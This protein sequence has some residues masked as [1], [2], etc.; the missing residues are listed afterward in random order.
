MNNNGQKFKDNID[1]FKRNYHKNF[2]ETLVPAL[3]GYEKKRKWSLFWAIFW[4]ILLNGL[5]IWYFYFIIVNNIK[6][7]R[8]EEPGIYLIGFG[9]AAYWMIKK[10]F[11]NKIKEKIMRPLCSCFGNMTWSQFYSFVDA[12]R[13]VEA[14]LFRQYSSYDV[15][16]AFVGTYKDC[17]IDIVE[18]EFT[19]GSGKNRSTVFNGLL[20]KLDMNK[21]FKGHTL[22]MEDKLFHKSP[23]SHLRHTELE[24]VVFE[25]KYDV[26]TDDEVEARY[27]LTPKLMDKLAKIKMAFRS[28]SIRCAFL[29]GQFLIAMENHFLQDLFSLGSLTKP[30][31]DPKQFT[32]LCRQFCSVLALI[33]HFELYQDSVL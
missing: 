16:D 32:R 29:D 33:D 26:F 17:N 19:A 15:D 4:T 7:R 18:A 22:L 13:F 8:V 27:I 1:D 31:S 2:Y 9:I 12:D 14:G 21:K 30:V 6:G 23:L 24:D 20:I 25:K 3:K 11:E 5:G 28:K 10:G